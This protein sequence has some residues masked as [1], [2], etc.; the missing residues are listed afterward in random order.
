MN[1]N[2]LRIQ[3]FLGLALSAFLLWLSLRSL[4]PREI[5]GAL[6]RANW[7][8]FVPI[9]LL[10]LV[11]FWV[12]AVRWGWILRGIKPIPVRRLFAA[13]MIGFTANNL[14]PARLGEVVRPW[15]LGKSEKIS[16]ASAFATIIVER[17]VDMFC[18]LLLF[19]VALALHPFPRLVQDAGLAALGV[20]LALL[21]VLLAIERSPAQAERVSAWV[22]RRAPAK[23]A[24]K[25]ASLLRNFSG[26]LGVFRSGM[27]L[28][29][30]TV[31]SAIMYTVT[32]IGLLG[33]MWAFDMTVPWYAGIVMLVITAFGMM[34]APT[35]GYLGAIQYA[36]V[37]GLSLF[38]IDRAIGFSFSLYYHLTQFL[39]ITVVGLIYLGRAGMSLGQ[40]ATASREGV[41]TSV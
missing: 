15:A 18:I 41:G 36:C 19:A 39:P 8:W 33:C 34:I 10:T 9:C 23:I 28:F 13:T 11:S 14:L 24:P 2:R 37:L 3:L 32:A 1:A 26:G 6:A 21:A 27:G 7:L 38:G 29:W 30:V 17:V 12:R 35:P 40:V 20:N 16:R 25:L 5:G 4:D 31:H 22:E